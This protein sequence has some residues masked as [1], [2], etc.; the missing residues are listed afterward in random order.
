MSVKYRLEI[1]LLLIPLLLLGTYSFLIA[2]TELL[3]GSYFRNTMGVL[4]WGLYL[5]VT[6]SALLI[7]YAIILI[8]SSLSYSRDI[9]P[10]Y[11]IVSL[12][13]TWLIGMYIYTSTFHMPA[14]QSSGGPFPEPSFVVVSWSALVTLNLI[15][16]LVFLFSKSASRHR[17][18]ELSF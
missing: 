13:P 1:I 10:V 17:I 8:K 2:R 7:S 15:I 9:S 4:Y 5:A 11:G 14:T 16:S 6:A 3:A 12:W 18:K